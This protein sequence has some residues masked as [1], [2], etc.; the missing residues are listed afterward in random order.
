[1]FHS[2][3]ACQGWFH[4]IYPAPIKTL[5]KHDLLNDVS[6]TGLPRDCREGGRAAPILGRQLRGEFQLKT[7]AQEGYELI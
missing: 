2:K 7:N 4:P 3:I 6:K 5:S 1:M